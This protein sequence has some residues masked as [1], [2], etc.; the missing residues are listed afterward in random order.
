MRRPSTSFIYNVLVYQ[1][2]TVIVE[3]IRGIPTLVLVFYF[4][5]A[6]VPQMVTVLNETGL[7]QMSA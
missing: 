2:A 6:F 7:R 5:L 3:F 1:P 4:T